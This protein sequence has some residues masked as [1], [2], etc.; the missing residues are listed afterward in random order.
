MTTGKQDARADSFCSVLGIASHPSLVTLR[1]RKGQQKGVL[2]NE[3]REETE[4]L[5]DCVTICAT[6]KA[7]LLS[8]RFFLCGRRGALSVWGWR[9][10]FGE[11]RNEEGVPYLARS[12][13]TSG[14]NSLPDLP[15]RSCNFL[16]QP[17][18]LA[19]SQ[20]HKTVLV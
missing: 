20:G 16:H 5:N 6:E 9:W 7:P 2:A 14:G 17:F 11:E 1:G 3:E 19:V 18:P 10:S 4:L 13:G 8:A 15:V 12:A